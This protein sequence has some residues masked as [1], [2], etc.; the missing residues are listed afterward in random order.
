MS[1]QEPPSSADGWPG[2]A[3]GYS[4]GYPAGY[5]E[6]STKVDCSETV[7]RI[8][9]FLDGEMSPDDCLR[10]QSHLDECGPCLR[11]YQ[12]DQALKMVIKRSCGCE[13]APV[14]LRTTILRRLTMVRIETTD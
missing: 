5:P 6:A 7:L 2:H 12:V 13:T 4:T 10:M 9:E 1:E 8:F 3:T 11:E 14:E